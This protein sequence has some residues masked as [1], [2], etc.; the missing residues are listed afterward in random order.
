MNTFG[1]YIW[2]G[3]WLCLPLY[4]WFSEETKQIYNRNIFKIMQNEKITF[5]DFSQML[6]SFVKWRN[7]TFGRHC[8]NNEIYLVR[9]NKRFAFLCAVNC[10]DN[11]FCLW[12]DNSAS[13][14]RYKINAQKP[15]S[16]DFIE[17][18]EKITKEYCDGIVHCSCCNKEIKK[19]EIA[20]RFFAG[21]YCKDCWEREYREKEAREDYN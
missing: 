21:I 19:N 10:H 7:D 15:P 4:P 1:D 6:A 20:G 3:T 2:Q 8:D 11:V 9:D 18:I 5:Q 16:D 12:N 17:W 14:G 13:L